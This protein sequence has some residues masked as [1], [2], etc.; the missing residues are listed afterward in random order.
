MAEVHTHCFMCGHPY[1][2]HDHS[3]ENWLA[4][5]DLDPLPGAL[6]L[7]GSPTM[8]RKQRRAAAKGQGTR[9]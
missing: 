9:K 2:I 5:P 4:C 6:P 8:N 1:H 3:T 7:P